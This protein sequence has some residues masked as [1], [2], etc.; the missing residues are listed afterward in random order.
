MVLNNDVKEIL[1]IEKNKIALCYKTGVSYST[2]HRWLR[3][4]H[5]KLTLKKVSEAI[6]EIAKIPESELFQKEEMTSVYDTI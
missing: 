3:D 2:I 1:A 5:E 6:S 4:D